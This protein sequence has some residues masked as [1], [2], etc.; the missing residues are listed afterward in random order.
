[1]LDNQN[2]IRVT[3]NW[4][5]F[6][7]LGFVLL[8]IPSIAKAQQFPDFFPW[9]IDT[10]YVSA[11]AAEGG[12]G[13][14]S[15]PY[16]NWD[17][18]SF[19]NKTAYLFKRG[20]EMEVNK[21]LVVGTDSIFFGGYGDGARPHFKGTTTNKHFYFCGTQQYIQGINIQC[22]DTGTCITFVGDSSKF[23]WAD[24][25]ELSHAWWGT[26]PSGYGK[27]IL[28]NL[29]VH[30]T[31]VD[32]I[33][34]SK[35]DT[36]I[37]KNTYM[38]DVNRWYEYI[39]DINTSGGDC[40]QGESN[41]FVLID[42]CTLDHSA[43]PGKFALILNGSDTAIIKNSKITGYDLS[44]TVYVGSSKRGWHFD[45]C[46]ILGGKYGLWNHG[47]LVVQNCVFKD[48]WNNSI[49]SPKGII[50]NNI[51]VDNPGG[52]AYES[53]SGSIAYSRGIVLPVS[54]DNTQLKIYNNIFYNVK[55][56]IECFKEYVGNTILMHNNNYYNDITEFDEQPIN[57]FGENA[58]NVNPGFNF[59][60]GDTTDYYL[61]PSSP[62]I[63]AAIE[64]SIFGISLAT[65]I[66]GYKR[67][68][69]NGYDIGPYEYYKT[70]PVL[71]RNE[72]NKEKSVQVYPNPT[73][74]M[75]NIH[76][77]DTE[78]KISITIYTTSGK[79]VYSNPVFTSSVIN[80]SGLDNGLYLV[81]IFSGTKVTDIKLL[82]N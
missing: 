65:D 12:D 60:I 2:I 63:D 70:D 53:S 46:K 13:S 31:R 17:D 61:L 16:N 23:L 75:V 25:M 82:K 59:N 4:F 67:P 55:Q 77:V 79:K 58:F 15:A 14:I 20:V 66:N 40:I 22:Q 8:H 9:I 26:N 19:D 71:N 27:I 21:K 10:V 5:L 30:R 72:I 28:S 54:G 37:I 36:I 56:S 7:F 35:N 18:F 29:Y 47:D 3:I 81:K 68:N 38:H 76:T 50:C 74:G 45:G 51:F 52:R 48:N 69:G 57:Q 11:D 80:L 64:P 43:N 39:Q 78:E 49:L 1:M 62:M 73:R 33:Y 24:S 34:A 44:A 32:G 42:G 6:V 41:D